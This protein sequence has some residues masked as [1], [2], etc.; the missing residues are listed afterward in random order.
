MSP[1]KEVSLHVGSELDKINVCMCGLPEKKARSY[2][3]PACPLPTPKW[4]A[5]LRGRTASRNFAWRCLIIAQ[6]LKR[7]IWKP[8]AIVASQ[9]AALQSNWTCTP[10]ARAGADPPPKLN[11]CTFNRYL[12]R[13]V[14]AA[15]ITGATE[16]RSSSAPL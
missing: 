6:Q 13:S 2:P 16:Q 5:E 4:A 1:I 12:S 9:L 10:H 11:S 15:Q 3:Q 8:H 7:R 14:T